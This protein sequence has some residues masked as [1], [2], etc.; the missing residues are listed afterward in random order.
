MVSILIMLLFWFAIWD[1]F[2]TSYYSV[3]GCSFHSLLFSTNTENTIAQYKHVLLGVIYRMTVHGYVATYVYV[4]V[5][6][7]LSEKRDPLEMSLCM[8][9]LFII[10]SI[11]A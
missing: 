7:T 9:T 2:N 11:K 8:P 10:Q 6:R 3:C 1:T 5:G 4:S